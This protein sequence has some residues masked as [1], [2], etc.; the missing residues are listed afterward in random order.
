VANPKPSEVRQARAY[1]QKQGIRSGDISPL[2]LAAS[3][4][5]M[6][7]S[8]RETL[9]FVAVLLSGG[10]GMGPSR[11]ASRNKDRLDPVQAAGDQLKNLSPK[12]TVSDAS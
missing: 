1:L 3:A 2:K 6:K 7:K 9:R 5:E 4:K 8:Y 10:S 12:S 11:I